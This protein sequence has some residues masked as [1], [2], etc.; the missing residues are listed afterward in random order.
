VLGVVFLGES[1]SAALVVGI[2]LVAVA[3]RL[4]AQ[5]NVAGDAPKARGRRRVA[6]S[7]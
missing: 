1:L 5:T 6:R 4:A 7:E 2:A 3:V